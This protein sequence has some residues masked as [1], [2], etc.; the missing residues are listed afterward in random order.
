MDHIQRAID[1]FGG[2]QKLAKAAGVSVQAIS[3]WLNGERQITPECAN[4]I[5]AATNGEVSRDDLRPDI[6]GPPTAA[7]AEGSSRARAA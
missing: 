6:F 4:R 7:A 2:R 3:F 1:H 5:H